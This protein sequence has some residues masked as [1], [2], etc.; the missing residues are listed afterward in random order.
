MKYPKPNNTNTTYVDSHCHLDMDS[1]QDDFDDILSRAASAGISDIITIG[2]DYNSSV[3]AI[4]LSRKYAQIHASIGIHPHDVES[5]NQ[6]TYDQLLQLATANSEHICAFGE[7]GLDYFKNY[8]PVSLQRKHFELQLDLA[9]SLKLPVIIHDRDAHDDVLSI[10]R[11]AGPFPHGG[12]MHCF[13][14]DY[15]LAK[16]IFDLGFYIS[17]PGVVTFKN[18]AQLQEVVKRSPLSSMLVETDGPFLCPMPNRGKRNEP[19]FI[20]FIG[21]KIAELKGI[22]EEEVART[23]TQNAIRLFS[24]TH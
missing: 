13:S 15:T 24:L 19:A 9:K 7:I 18:S 5:I 23:T 12:V 2:I 8:A 10:I 17:I 4:E 3:K 1:Y 22:N 16:K 11:N 14:G 21:R 20:P 6:T